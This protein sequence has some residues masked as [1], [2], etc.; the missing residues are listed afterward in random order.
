MKVHLVILVIGV[1]CACDGLIV[2]AGEIPAARQTNVCV[3]MSGAESHVTTRRYHRITSDEVWTRIWQEHEGPTPSAQDGLYHG[4]LNLPVI[5]FNDYM[6]IGVF[7]GEL[8]NCTG[9][10]AVSIS[11]G[12]NSIV[13]RYDKYGYQTLGRDGRSEGVTAAPYGF[14]IL[15]LSEKPVVVEENVQNEL[16]QPPVWK[17]RIMFPRLPISGRKTGQP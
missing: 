8:R 6:V 16:G 2:S 13:F 15:R 14:F 9:L 7:Q 12:E 1:M 3:A 10:K 17:E 4:H 5:D 11:E